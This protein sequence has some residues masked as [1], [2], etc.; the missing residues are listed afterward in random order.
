MYKKSNVLKAQCSGLGKFL[1]PGP[2]FKLT[3]NDFSEYVDVPAGKSTTV[4]IDSLTTVTLI[5]HSEQL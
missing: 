4:F 3:I 2:T 5:N 1:N